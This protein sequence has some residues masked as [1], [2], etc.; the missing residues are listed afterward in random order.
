MKTKKNIYVYNEI[1]KQKEL[2]NPL[3]AG[4]IKMYVCGL[5]VYDY[6]HIGNARPLVVFDFIRRFLEYSGYKVDFVHNFTDID[7]KMIK[8]AARDNIT[9]KELADK[10]IAEY[11]KDA[12]G[13]GA[14]PATINPK[15]TEHIKEI[16]DIIGILIKK[17][18]AYTSKA[19]ENG[20][21]DVYFSTKS[22]DGYGK[23]SNI[24]TDDLEA[25]DRVNA[26]IVEGKN[27]PLDFALWK[28]KKEGEPFWDSPWGAG[29]PGW[30]IECSAMAKKYLGDTMD[31]HCGG[32]DL[33]FP[34]HENEIAQ[35]ECAFGQIFANYWLHNGMININGAKMAK[36][37]GNFFTVRDISEKY[38]YMPIRFF[39]LSSTYRAPVNFSEEIIKS[40]KSSLE[41]I[42][43]FGENIEFLLKT[44]PETG[45]CVIDFS[46]YREKLTEALCDD[47]NTADAVSVLFDFIREANTK[48]MG[49]DARPS[50]ILLEKIKALYDEFCGLFGFIPEAKT[51]DSDISGDYITGQI[52]KRAAAKKAKDFKTADEIRDALKSLGIILEDAPSGTKWKRG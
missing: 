16:I 51:P 9:V 37:E 34:H 45:D 22:F 25:G 31:F 33:V 30:H 2:F 28:A 1:K 23:L 46:D 19:D 49:Q 20:N 8:R 40:A 21:F 13:L 5:T 44:A 3:S 48:I 11:K 32:K 50:K 7:D 12:A 29:R 47:F 36:S 26:D 38:G 15:A 27:D 17:N 41:R 43:N 35:S 6:M 24:N 52:E 4:E 10:F 18:H 39:L 42:F 14:R